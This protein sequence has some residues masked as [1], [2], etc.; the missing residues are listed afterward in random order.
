MTSREAVVDAGA[1]CFAMKLT[2]CAQCGAPTGN[3]PGICDRCLAGRKQSQRERNAAYDRLRDPERV[4]FYHSA[5]WKTTRLAKLRSVNFL[6]ED[7]MDECR[8][9]LR[10]PEEVRPATDV[11]HVVELAADWSL[12]LEWSNLRALCDAHHKAKRRH[13]PPGAGEKVRL[14]GM[15]HRMAS[16]MQQKLPHGGPRGRG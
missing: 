9:G 6:C 8:R 10:R 3:R 16:P 4:K 1:F 5:V 2:L 14:I 7:C 13:C 11:H 12:R 15:Q